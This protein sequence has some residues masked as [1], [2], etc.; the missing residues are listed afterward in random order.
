MNVFLASVGR[1]QCSL[2]VHE[3]PGVGHPGRGGQ[4]H[5]EQ[6][7]HTDRFHVRARRESDLVATRLA[8]IIYLL[9]SNLLLLT[10]QRFC[11]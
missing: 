7:Q 6:R 5:Q 10:A 11:L 1:R 3:R 9:F 4:G 8:Q 2:H